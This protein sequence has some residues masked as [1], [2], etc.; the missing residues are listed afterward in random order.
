MKLYIVRHGEAAPKNVDSERHLNENGMIE[1]SEMAAFFNCAGIKVDEIWHSTKER[2]RRT[3]VIIAEAVPHANLVERAGLAPEDPVA[4][5]ADEINQ[6]HEDIIIVG[7][8]P[9][10]A[11]LVSH[12]LLGAENGQ[13]V[14]F[15]SAAAV[16]LEKWESGWSLSWMMDP[17]ILGKCIAK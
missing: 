3:A 15:R 1:V 12:L 9:F 17:E 4:N 8:L 14:N 10:L 7:H 13:I 5:L 16:C 2:A 6:L 11:L